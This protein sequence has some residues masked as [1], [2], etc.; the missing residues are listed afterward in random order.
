MDLNLGNPPRTQL[1]A[2]RT[3]IGASP[4]NEHPSAIQVHPLGNEVKPDRD[5]G[6]SLSSQRSLGSD[7]T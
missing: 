5:N 4:H 1:S 6:A 3:G 2:R 7:M